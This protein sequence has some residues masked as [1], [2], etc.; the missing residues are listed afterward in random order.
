MG[1]AWALLPRN[2]LIHGYISADAGSRVR[3]LRPSL[4]P[5][6]DCDLFPVEDLVS[7][8][9]A[10]NS[11]FLFLHQ[12]SIEKGDKKQTPW[13]DWVYKLMVEKALS[14]PELLRLIFHIS[15]K[16]NGGWALSQKIILSFEDEEHF[17]LLY[18][19]NFVPAAII[20]RFQISKRDPLSGISVPFPNLLLDNYLAATKAKIRA[21]QWPRKSQILCL[22]IGHNN[23]HSGASGKMGLTLPELFRSHFLV[24]INN[25][26]QVF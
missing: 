25:S 23:S 19:V 6:K 4:C 14:L 22:L 17:S 20:I 26:F 16:K 10:D 11:T 2:L 12:G 9:K 15:F 7:Q 5:L 3:L 1:I 8:T 24:S 13:N 18:T 21:A